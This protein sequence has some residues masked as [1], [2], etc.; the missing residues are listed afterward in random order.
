MI[1]KQLFGYLYSE[2]KDN[3]IHQVT[4]WSEG[5]LVPQY[6]TVFREFRR[7]VEVALCESA[8]VSLRDDNDFRF[9]L[10]LFGGQLS[11]RVELIFTRVTGFDLLG[12]L[13]ITSRPYSSD[14][15]TLTLPFTKDGVMIAP[16]S[17]KP[18]LPQTSS[19]NHGTIQQHA[20]Q[21]IGLMILEAVPTAEL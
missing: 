5:G 9:E 7:K 1:A 20:E 10:D 15:E 19:E 13:H 4:R 21:I 12:S 14:E 11:V 17:G 6:L 2:E 18:A 8:C 16:D 3:A